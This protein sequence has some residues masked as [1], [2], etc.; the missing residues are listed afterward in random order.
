MIGYL[1]SIY[2]KTN[3]TKL[4]NNRQ[5]FVIMSVVQ[6]KLRRTLNLYNHWTLLY[7]ISEIVDI[8]NIGG[9]P[10]FND[11]IVKFHTYNTTFGHRDKDTHITIRFIYVTV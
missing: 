8:L 9:E 6:T 5:Y 11:R 7:E 3:F 2:N 4:L 1:V 10:L